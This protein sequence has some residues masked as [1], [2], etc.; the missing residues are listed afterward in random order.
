MPSVTQGG[1]NIHYE[2]EGSGPALVLH[3]GAGGDLRI[4]REAGYV[5][6][7][8]GFRLILIDQRGRGQSS[9][10][11]RREDHEVSRYVSD[12]GS[13]L[14]EVGVE[15]SGFWGYSNGAVV[16]IAFGAIFPRRLQALIGTG[17]VPFVD[18]NEL[19][20]IPDA[21]EFIAQE[22][23]R[24]GVRA[25]VD[26]FVE[27]EHDRFPDE[28]DRNVRETDPVMGALRRLAW[29]SWHGPKSVLPSFAAPVLLITG[30]KENL[31]GDNERVLAAVPNGRMVRIPGHGHL[32]AFYRSDLAI[33]HAIPFLRE[34]LR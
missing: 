33:P 8:T 14:D 16:G 30:E 19:P 18:F 28:I 25:D 5:T 17:V 2:V 34:H 15:S 7:L 10:P 13:V 21:E 20:P 1:V 24:G 3:T 4:W 12:I 29:R 9:R 11:T 23:A 32:G 22:V 26:G 27:E 6:G 31:E